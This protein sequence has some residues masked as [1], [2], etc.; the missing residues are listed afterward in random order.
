LRRSPPE[1]KLVM[2]TQD[3]SEGPRATAVDRS[4]SSGR[5]GSIGM[6]LVVAV[7][8]VGAAV[9][10]LLVGRGN[11][12][13]YILALLAFLAMTGVF[14]LFAMATGILRLSGKDT[15]HPMLKAV[16]DEATDGLIVT[17]PRGRVIY[18]NAAYLELVDAKD[19]RDVR[20]VE[21]VFIGD[22]DVSEAVYR[23]LKA[24]R[25]GR[26]AHEEVRVTGLKGKAV[27]WLRL[28]VRPLAAGGRDGKLTVW[29]VT[30]V[31]RDRERQENIF[32]EL[33][34]A[35]D[36]LDH[37]PAGFFSVDGNGDIGYL[38]ATLASWLDHDLAQVGSGG[39]K[40]TDIVSG[41]GAS[42]ITTLAAAPGEVKTE[43]MDIDFKT[44]GGRTVP[45]RLFHKVAFGA[46]GMPGASR[47]LVLNRAKGETDAVGAPNAAEVRFMRF[48]QSTPMAIAT[49]DKAGKISRTNALFTRMFPGALKDGADNRSIIATVAERDR[50]AFEGA[51]R[52][53]AG[54]QSEVAP[55]DAALSGKDERYGRFYVSPVEEED[56]DG[57]AAI[58]YVLET[59]GQ[60][61]LENQINQR[62][63]MESIGELAG[64]IAHD[65]N[66]VLSA[67]M[68]ATDF[69][70]N[71]HK[72]T[73]PSFGDIMQI[74]QNANRAASL[75]RQLLAFSRRQTLRPQV[76]DLGERLED[77]RI[78]L[79][80]LIGEKVKLEVKHDR[81]LWPVKADISQFEQV[82][83]NLA[84]NARDA[85]P[86]GGKLNI[87]TANVTADG[88]AKL[89]YKGM[90]AADYVL[91]EVADTGTG[92][93]QDIIGKIFDPF[94]ST[95][96][97][98]KG[99]GLGLSTV[100]GIVKQTGGFVYPDSETGKGTTFRIFLPR[101]VANAAEEAFDTLHPSRDAA[102]FAD[103]ADAPL[104]KIASPTSTSAVGIS[105]LPPTGKVVATP[106]PAADLTGQ[107]TIL[108][109]EDEEGLRAL[110]ARG[111][112]SRG[113]SVLEAGNGV[114]AIDVLIK[115]GGHVDLVVSDVVMPEMDGPTLLKELRKRNPALKII[116]VSGYA[117]EA[118]A[119][120]L[121]QGEQFSFLP[122]PFTLKQ[123]VGAVKETMSA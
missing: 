104:L 65:F 76:L 113:Y 82:I 66:N 68:M 94:F 119:K 114:E 61:S 13:P 12:G 115:N 54:G 17:D 69:L 41:N 111:L 29:T 122:K 4:E 78:M 38:N 6:V 51:I 105:T 87:R 32:Q 16:I 47:T 86:N 33:Q 23:L 108:L 40:L 110:N 44:R 53:A 99:T 70:L 34:H 36:Y 42:L 43:V 89:R 63:R 123:L 120:S 101:H 75:V 56:R 3:L 91:V 15:G 49:V 19:E 106:P 92:I 80:R 85:M 25:E 21:R 11:A 2:A 98:G 116:F 83:V 50:E 109:V 20:P 93:P 30:D 27:N 9:G 112:A 67:I 35:I 8:L 14:S 45:V 22:P 96:E 28:R 26:K 37:A 71:A 39:L 77:L 24:A 60:R 1:L 107:G 72:P 48:F 100:Y 121:P 64:G 52:K 7:A 88:A 97:V 57:E 90:P 103:E 84:V 5:G 46:D 102:I 58:V 55:V 79:S 73:D 18:A 31:T 10:L 118:F 117:E 59:T 95:K 62:A 74:K 81:D